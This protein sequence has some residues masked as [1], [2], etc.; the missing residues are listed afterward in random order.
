MK[1]LVITLLLMIADVGFCL[2]SRGITERKFHG[3]DKVRFLG[4][5][6]FDSDSRYLAIGGRAGRNPFVSGL[7]ILLKKAGVPVDY[8]LLMGDLGIAFIMPASDKVMLSDGTI[9]VR[10]WAKTWEC[11]PVLLDAY[12]AESGVDVKWIAGPY[13]EYKKNPRQFYLNTI[14]KDVEQNIESGKLVLVCGED[15]R[16]VVGY[17]VDSS[18]LFGF[19]PVVNNAY[20]DV[21]SGYPGFAVFMLKKALPR[22]DAKADVAGLRRAVALGRDQVPMPNGYVTGQKAFALWVRIL[23]ANKSSKDEYVHAE[24]VSNLKTNRSSAVNYLRYM[25]DRVPKAAVAHLDKAVTSYI[26]IL[27]ILNSADIAR[28]TL[29]SAAGREKLAKQVDEIAAMEA[30]AVDEIEQALAALQADKVKGGLQ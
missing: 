1:I 8:E 5:I 19:N 18:R 24:L 30:Q 17:Q 3:F 21:L 11:L 23:R 6:K 2:E 7:D 14:K 15:W 28:S 25:L 26:Q 29:E 22:D 9:D 16:I 10:W 27:K 20:I 4:G 12:G 13:E